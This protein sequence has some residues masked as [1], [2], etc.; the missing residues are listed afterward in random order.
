VDAIAARAPDVRLIR[1][2]ANR[3][4]GHALRKG[5]AEARGTVIA[6]QDADLEL[7][8]Q[9]L[10]ALVDPILRGEAAVIYGSRFLDGRPDAPWLTVFANQVLTEVTNTLY[11]CALTDMET[12]YKI[13]DGDV[14]RGLRLEA[15][16]FDIEPEI[17]AKLLARSSDREKPVRFQ[18]RSKAAARRF[19]GATGCSA[20]HSARYR[21]RSMA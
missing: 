15:D 11:G 7:D 4:K 19:D 17:T 6:I 18:A 12:C 1:S 20:A 13:L 3:G 16:R 5:L 8:P 2:P 21:M 10:A 14:A 9:Q